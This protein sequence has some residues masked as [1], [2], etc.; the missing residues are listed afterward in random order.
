[1]GIPN[2]GQILGAGIGPDNMQSL[3]VDWVKGFKR[4][5]MVME[6]RVHDNK[7][8]YQAFSVTKDFR[9]HWV[10]F[11]LGGKFDWEIKNFVL[12]SQL[13]YIKSLNYHYQFENQSP[14]SI[15]I[16]DKQDVNNLHLKSD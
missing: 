13:V 4:I 15:F 11:G 2:K 8:Y 1:M 7:L 9:R 14:S 5:G 3:N 12:N 10:D 6:R 16:W